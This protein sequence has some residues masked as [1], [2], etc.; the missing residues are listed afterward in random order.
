MAMI[1]LQDVPDELYRQFKA[2]CA[3]QGKTI[4][5]AFIEMMKERLERG[6]E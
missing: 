2:L 4:K 6:K 3:L 1:N 5:E